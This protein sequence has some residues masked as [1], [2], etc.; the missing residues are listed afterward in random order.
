MKSNKRLKIITI[1]SAVIL[2]GLLGIL[3]AVLFSP[4]TKNDPVPA[5]PENTPPESDQPATDNP[6]SSLYYYEADKQA[7]YQAYHDANPSFTPDEVVWRV[8]AHVDVPGYTEMDTIAPE[9]AD[10]VGQLINKHYRLADDYVPRKLAAL[11]NGLL[12]TPE[13][14]TAY[15]EMAAAAAREGIYFT[16]GSTYRSVDYQRNLY[17]KYVASDGQESAD[18]YSARPGSSE[19]HTGRAIDFIGPSGTLDSFEGTPPSQWIGENSW[20]YGFIVRYT[21]ENQDVTKYIYEP[22]HITYVG[23]EIAQTMKNETINTLEEYTVKFVDHQ[24]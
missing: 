23:K 21:Q 6:Y 24:K 18:T 9:D 5:P 8:N 17:N 13:T 7:R 4:E 16:P 15:D 1:I 14:K 10:K 11:D 3:V 20:Q 19:H 22:W 12:V 2:I